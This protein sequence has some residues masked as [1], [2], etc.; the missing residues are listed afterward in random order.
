MDGHAVVT[1]RHRSTAKQ[2]QSRQ[3]IEEP[4]T[5][6]SWA[7]GKSP[8]GI[9]ALLAAKISV[10]NDELI[11]PYG[12]ALREL[13][14]RVLPPPEP[15]TE[16]GLEQL[17]DRL[18]LRGPCNLISRYYRSEPYRPGRWLPRIVV[19]GFPWEVGPGEIHWLDL[20]P[21]LLRTAANALRPVFESIQAM[22]TRP[23]ENR[24]VGLTSQ[25]IAEAKELIE[26]DPVWAETEPLVI[27]VRH[28]LLKTA[29]HADDRAEQ[30]E[31]T[32]TYDELRML[33]LPDF[34]Q[35]RKWGDAQLFELR[36][37][38]ADLCRRAR[39]LLR[40]LVQSRG[41]ATRAVV[42]RARDRLKQPG[43]DE[44]DL[45]RWH[46]QKFTPRRLALELLAAHRQLSVRRL[47]D[48][49]QRSR[50]VR[51]IRWAWV[52]FWRTY[53]AANLSDPVLA[54][55]CRPPPGGPR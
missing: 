46:R 54:A 42:Q 55:L 31:A 19:D 18:V 7:A 37:E 45:R 26:F 24:P 53:R 23:V 5:I 6:R 9:Y 15:G 34:S 21:D 8:A 32:V 28:E 14:C 3:R 49:L 22:A 10:L 50:R 11:E 38:Y 27:F 30:N 20:H 40:E 47:E 1:K 4:L 39:L 25:L 48:L 29:Y 16:A 33:A 35:Q 36:Q 13:F 51:L 12:P 43:I 17:L 52:L 44:Q 41:R 2:L